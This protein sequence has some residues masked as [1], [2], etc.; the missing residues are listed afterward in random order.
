MNICG[1]FIRNH[2][3]QNEVAHFSNAERKELS[4]QNSISSEKCFRHKGEIKPFSNEGKMREFTARTAN[5]RTARIANGHSSGRGEMIP[6]R[7]KEE[8]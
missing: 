6:E 2:R 8:Q 7:M 5:A 4:I 1:F 3:G